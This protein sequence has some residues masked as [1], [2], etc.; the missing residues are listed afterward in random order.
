[1]SKDLFDPDRAISRG[2]FVTVLG[3][4]SGVKASDYR[5]SVFKDVNIT[6]YCA[7]YIG[8]AY[9]E[10]IIKGYADKT[11]KADNKISREEM[12]VICR[13]FIDHE[14]IAIPERSINKSFTEFTDM[15]IIGK[16]AA[17]RSE[18]R[19]VGKECR[20]RWSPYH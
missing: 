17:E 3:R 19:R 16:W 20:S 6:V 2:E 1:M 15:K 8:W 7:P 4:M 18:E 5:E 13:N 12:A 10:G 9:K 11:F 14:K